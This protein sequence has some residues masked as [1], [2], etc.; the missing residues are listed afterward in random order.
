MHDRRSF[1][2]RVILALCMLAGT[3]THAMTLW[4][5]GLWW[6]YG[7]VPLFTQVYW[8]SLTFLDPLAALLLF[9]RP[10]TGLVMT[11][12]II[13]SDVA[14]NLWFIHHYDIGFNWG[15]AL[16]CVFLIFVAATF[17]RVWRSSPVI[18]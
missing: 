13:S 10:R 7:G 15:V 16:Q 14:H 12:A 6:D 17:R 18:A 8:T 4:T 3:S 9:V 2:L 5:H 11:A 1:I